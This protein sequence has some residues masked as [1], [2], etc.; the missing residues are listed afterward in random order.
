MTESRGTYKTE[1]HPAKKHIIITFRVT[2]EERERIRKNAFDAGCRT[3][4][5]YLRLLCHLNET[6]HSFI[7]ES[8]LRHHT[9]RKETALKNPNASHA[10]FAPPPFFPNTN[11][12]TALGG[13]AA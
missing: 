6:N 3:E 11:P 2:E 4:R 8:G 9:P 10:P 13:T 12:Q 7:S 5:E 1:K